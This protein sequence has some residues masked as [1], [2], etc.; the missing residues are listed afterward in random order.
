[1]SFLSLF[2]TSPEARRQPCPR[3]SPAPA[4]DSSLPVLQKNQAE[5]LMLPFPFFPESEDLLFCCSS[6][7]IRAFSW[8]LYA[9]GSHGARVRGE[10]ERIDVL[11][12]R[13]RP[14]PRKLRQIRSQPGVSNSLLHVFPY[15][16]N[17]YCSFERGRCNV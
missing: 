8:F 17:R 5:L 2:L 1:V 13:G 11:H 16:H 12:H 15:K 14:H 3:L 9:S 10:L 7:F 6:G 4:A